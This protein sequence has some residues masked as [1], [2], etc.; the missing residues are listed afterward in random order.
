MTYAVAFDALTSHGTPG[1]GN[2]TWNHTAGASPKGVIVF[3]VQNVG[4]TDEVSGVTY[5][6]VNMTEVTGS[7]FARATGEPGTVYAYFLG[8]GVPANTQSV[9]VTVTNT[10]V[11]TATAITVTGTT[12]L[13]KVQDIDITITT[14]GGTSLSATLALGGVSSFCA[15]AF[16][17]GEN[18]PSSNT[19]LANWTSAYAFDFT[20]QTMGV[21]YYD[22]ISTVDVTMGWTQ[23]SDDALAIGVAIA[24]STPVVSSLP[25]SLYQADQAGFRQ[26]ADKASRRY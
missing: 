1:T 13:T 16:H 26:K 23:S 10:S 2:L 4:A 7:P 22:I 3:I 9:V 15:E 8:A 20:S 24:D 14:T 6:G 19:P 17:S 12:S 21:Y 5:G 18:A 11:K 25:N